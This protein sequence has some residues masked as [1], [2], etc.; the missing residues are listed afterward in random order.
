MVK[1][2]DIILTGPAGKTAG[3]VLIILG[4]SALLV[5]YVFFTI[6]DI[7]L[8][9]LACIIGIGFIREGA[10][11][12]DKNTL[13]RSLLVLFGIAG[14]G[15]G[16]F[17]LVAQRIVMFSIKDIIGIWAIITGIGYIVSVFTSV[18]GF[19][20]IIKAISGLALGF[21]GVILL[22]APV[23]LTDFILL[24]I[25]GLFA[26]GLGILTIIFAS[27]KPKPK[28]EINHLIYK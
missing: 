8:A 23:L 12:V 26:I 7:F 21:L 22:I 28:A 11:G 4:I 27:D 24:L 15:I 9:V 20:R 25:L 5:P 16:I 3:V 17:L 2:P 10:S 19:D 14:I 1:I 13:N 6:L 18:T